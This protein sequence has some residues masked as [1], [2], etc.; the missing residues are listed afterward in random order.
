MTW[1]ITFGFCQRCEIHTVNGTDFDDFVHF[2]W[3]EV[4]MWLWI[5]CFTLLCVVAVTTELPRLKSRL[6][7]SPVDNLFGDQKDFD[8]LFE[9]FLFF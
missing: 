5:G 6:R 2:S 8:Y 3:F 1:M 7:F 9:W 4:S